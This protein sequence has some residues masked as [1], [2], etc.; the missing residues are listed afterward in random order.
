MRSHSELRPAKAQGDVINPKGDAITTA[1]KYQPIKRR[2]VAEQ[3]LDD[4]RNQILDGTLARGA[5]LPTERA[6]ADGY[7]VSAPTI[8]EAIRALEAMRL[9]EVRH[10]SGAFVTADADQLIAVSLH[11]MILLERVGIPDIVAVLGE[12]NAYAAELAAARATEEDI[13]ELYLSLAQVTASKD[14]DGIAAGLI[15]FLHGLAAASRNPLLT[16]LCKFLVG[17]Q[18]ELARELAGESFEVWRGISASLA[19]ERQQLV[20]AISARNPRDARRLA[21]IYHQRAVEVIKTLPGADAARLSDPNFSNFVA[22][23]MRRTP[24]FH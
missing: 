3:I 13:A 11:S 21:R 18:F 7:G 10:G 9:V 17:L 16:A 8:R 4:L 6:L 20:D 24:M 2:G 12:L 1:E 23:L 15:E 22:S 19:N 14:S 5:K